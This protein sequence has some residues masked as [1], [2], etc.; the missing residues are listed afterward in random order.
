MHRDSKNAPFPN[1]VI[2]K[3]DF[4]GGE[5]WV[6]DSLGNLPEMT[7]ESVR[8]GRGVKVAEGPVMFDAFRT[9]HFTRSWTRD[10]L[11]LVAYVTEGHEHLAKEDQAWLEGWGSTCRE[12][13]KRRRLSRSTA[14]L[15][16]QTSSVPSFAEIGG[17]PFKWSGRPIRSLSGMGL[18]CAL[19]RGGDLRTGE[20]FCPVLE[21][22]DWRILTEGQDSYCTGVFLRYDVTI[23][24][25][26]HKVKRRR[27]DDDLPE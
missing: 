12:R 5:I 27:F 16:N 22:P 18:A 14:L 8:L 10:R 3:K 13:G 2:P 21:D 9:F 15:V 25:L 23:P 17:F 19:Q 24:H 1:L 20:A 6:E 7:P 11:I 26:P 4:K